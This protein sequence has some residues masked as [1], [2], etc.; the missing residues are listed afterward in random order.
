MTKSLTGMKN[1]YHI[2]LSIAS[3]LALAGC[4]KDPGPSDANL[5][6]VEASI[7]PQTKVDYTNG[8]VSSSFVAGDKIA[9]YAWTGSASPVPATRAVD[10][11]VNTLGS[12]GWSPASLMRW[13]SM[14]ATHYFLGV[15][16]VHAISNFTADPYTLD[17]D[18]YTAS[19]LLVAT[20]PSGIAPTK[21]PISLE[22]SHVMAKLVVNLTFRSQWSSAPTVTSVTV[23]AKKT[24][25]VNYLAKEVTAT[26]T[27]EAVAL[28]ATDNAS[29][30]G[31]QIPQTGVA[32]I[33]VRIGNTDYVYTHST[34]I[35]LAGGQYTTI[36]L[37]VGRDKLELDQTGISITDWVSG[38]A[39]F[40]G[41]LLEGLNGHEF[42]DMGNGLKWATCNVGAS[43]PEEY[44]DF[45]AWAEKKTKNA[46]TWNSYKWMENN[47]LD[48]IYRINKYTHADGQTGGI[49][50]NDGVFV[51][52]AKTSYAD[53][54]YD[55]DAALQQWGAPW[56][57]PT[58]DE[59]IWLKKNCEW[60][61]TDDYNGTGIP[62]EIGTSKINGKSLFFPASGF[63]G[64][65]T[66]GNGDVIYQRGNAC[67]L[68]SSENGTGFSFTAR[69][70][71][72]SK[73]S[74]VPFDPD[75]MRR[76]Y[77]LS[78]RPVAD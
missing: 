51:G 26:G 58:V 76:F 23:G 14:T 45:Y 62:G 50:Y 10:G 18:Q 65:D 77:G 56:R 66:A 33:T 2:V 40:S 34:D 64:S 15:S 13:K 54:K 7:G 9:V 55:D 41:E 70:M 32:T 39:F 37:N 19:D 68:W 16:P 47:S 6:T 29:W 60:N 25:T 36:N 74:S 78:I 30:S 73:N 53:Y 59:W 61:W 3:L 5:I 20:T 48:L 8:G 57:T 72:F 24:G 31:L 38:E 11:V 44:G 52:D 1:L 75:T 46:Y 21:S 17:P 63:K 22:F 42:V 49:W 28:S 67:Y 43:K 35:P 71:P 69:Y 12:G 4:L 27:V